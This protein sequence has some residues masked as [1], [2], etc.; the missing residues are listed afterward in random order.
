MISLSSV[1]GLDIVDQEHH[2]DVTNRTGQQ[3]DFTHIVDQI[4]KTRRDFQWVMMGCYPLPLKPF[5]DNGEI[6]L[7]S[8]S[9]IL[10]Y[11][12]AMHNLNLN[13]TI[14]PL[15]DCHFQQSQE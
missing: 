12:K 10:E 7:I 2:I 14:A 8:W 6:E 3:D 1:Q 11:P 5:V 4:I 15:V 13:A 9:T